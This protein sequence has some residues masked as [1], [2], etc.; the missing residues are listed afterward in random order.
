MLSAALTGAGDLV[1]EV[2]AL[3]RNLIVHYRGSGVELPEETRGQIHLRGLAEIL[4]ADQARHGSDL[5]IPR[6]IIDR[7]QGCC[8][9]HTLFCVGALRYLGV[10]A[11]S[12]VGFASYLAPGWHH[13][14]VIVEAW[15][16]DRW[17]RFDPE[18]ENPRQAIAL[19]A[20]GFTD[21]GA[22]WRGFRDGTVDV[23]RYGVGQGLAAGDW[24]VFDY[25]ID[26]VAHRFGDEL[27]LWD[28]WGA[29]VESLTDVPPDDLRLV[30]RVAG[31]SVAADAGDLA[32]ERELFE[33]YLAD[34]R[35]HPGPIV[36]G[37]L[38]RSGPYLPPG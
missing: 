3:A 14:H 23:S 28:V 27:L 24:F 34:E 13:D 25:V 18:I 1:G 32:A 2:S 12:R 7:V 31:L 35:L 26:E 9:D 38:P 6:P 36:D 19:P 10:P 33:L 30:D 16:V 20:D 22:L 11:R 4:E 29:K 15:L 17:V 8:R 21:A 5:S 37:S